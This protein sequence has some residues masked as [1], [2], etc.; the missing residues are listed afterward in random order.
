MVHGVKTKAPPI[1][2][3]Y[4][5]AAVGQGSQARQMGRQTVKASNDF[6]VVVETM[7][8]PPDHLSHVVVIHTYIHWHVSRA[9]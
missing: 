9:S 4:L 8:Q 1:I 3:I 7:S 2:A 6:G 5:A